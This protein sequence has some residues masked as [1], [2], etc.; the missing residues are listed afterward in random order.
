MAGVW[1]GGRGAGIIES[2]C[3]IRFA[4]EPVTDEGKVG[5]NKTLA[6]GPESSFILGT[7]LCHSVN[8]IC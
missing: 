7:S 6:G 1:G 5:W 3:I 4:G 8:L 2:V